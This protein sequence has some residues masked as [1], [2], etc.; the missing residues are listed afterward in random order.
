MVTVNEFNEEENG[1]ASVER[2]NRPNSSE[3]CRQTT[4]EDM[5]GLR[6]INRRVHLEKQLFQRFSYVFCCGHDVT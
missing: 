2:S 6:R 3:L 1:F 4:E 5:E